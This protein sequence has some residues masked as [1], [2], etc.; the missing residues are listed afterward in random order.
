[1]SKR[2]EAGWRL[3]ALIWTWTVGGFIATLIAFAGL[4]LGLVDI[5]LQLITGW[6]IISESGMTF[7]AIAGSL[8]WF[9]DIHIFAFTGQRGFQWLPS[10]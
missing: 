6:D 9:V 7:N 2:T 5:I 10:L 3:V 4:I 1:M 8:Q